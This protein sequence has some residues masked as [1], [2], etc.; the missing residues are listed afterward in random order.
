EILR[1]KMAGLDAQGVGTKA[2]PPTRLVLAPRL[3]EREPIA[4]ARSALLQ[5]MAELDG[6]GS[7]AKTAASAGGV[8]SVAAQT[9]APTF[10]IRGYELRGNTL[11]PPEVTDPILQE[12]I[13]PAVTFDSLREGLAE[14]QMA[15]RARGFIT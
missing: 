6:Q 10:E 1:Q 5:K 2:S 4:K 8:A 3:A 12:H 9:N 15:Y 14:L 13:S 11:L 7:G